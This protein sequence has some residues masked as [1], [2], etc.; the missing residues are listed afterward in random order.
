M[1]SKGLIRAE[2]AT[3]KPLPNSRFLRE[4]VKSSSALTAGW[5]CGQTAFLPASLQ[6]H[7][8]DHKSL[9]LMSRGAL[10]IILLMWKFVGISEIWPKYEAF[11]F[12]EIYFHLSNGREF[13]QLEYVVC[14]LKRCTVAMPSGDS[15]CTGQYVRNPEELDSMPTIF[16][17]EADGGVPMYWSLM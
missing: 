11:P 2:L 10:C 4:P 6:H 14:L 7:F 5:F 9:A 12:Y 17:G 8:Y 3:E 15:R 1:T 16:E 13:F